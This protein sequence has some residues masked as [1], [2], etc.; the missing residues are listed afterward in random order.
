MKL[1]K[2]QRT[3]LKDFYDFK[4]PVI[5]AP[6]RSGKTVLLQKIVRDN[7]GKIFTI[8]T[9]NYEMF[10]YFYAGFKNAQYYLHPQMEPWALIGDEFLI[11]ALFGKPSISIMT[12]EIKLDKWNNA[13]DDKELPSIKPD[14]K[15]LKKIM[16]KDIFNSEFF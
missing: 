14:I 9:P 8:F 16:P 13:H 2:Y 6:R 3:A 15:E 5:I 12:K 1:T 10:E 4:N 7:P 11:T